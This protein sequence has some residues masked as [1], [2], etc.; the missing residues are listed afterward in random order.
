ME[1]ILVVVDMQNDFITGPLGSKEAQELVPKVCEK[2]RQYKD[3]SVYFT[4]DTHGENYLETFE[5]QRLPVK[6]C[7]ENTEGWEL[8]HEIEKIAKIITDEGT[9]CQVALKDR[10]GAI[11]LANH[12]NE[13]FETD[14]QFEIELCG[15]LTDI[16]VVSNALLL[17]AYFPGTKITVD[18]NC[19]VGSTPEKHKAALEVMKSCQIDVIGE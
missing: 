19:C 15:L 7:I 3:D 8:D 4:L 16:C 9:S 5:G 6:H 2:I 18:A 13:H 14:E 12:I 10:F 1:K 17:R 11:A